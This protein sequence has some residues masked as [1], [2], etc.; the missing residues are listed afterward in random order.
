MKNLIFA[1]LFVLSFTKA[2]SQ[3]NVQG[4]NLI[5]QSY[6]TKVSVLVKVYDPVKKEVK[7]LAFMLNDDIKFYI[8]EVADSGYIISVWDFKPDT[9]K[10]N[11]YKSLDGEKG[12][13][14]LNASSNEYY[15]MSKAQLGIENTGNTDI[16]NKFKNLAY[17]DLWANNTQFFISLKDFNNK[18][19]PIYPH[20]RGFTWGFLTLPIKARFGNK[21]APFTFEEKINF[22]ISAGVKWQHVNTVYSASN[23][24]G[25]ISVG[26]VKL[27]KDNSAAAISLSAGYMYQYDKFQI[28]IFTG[29]DFIDKSRGIDWGYQGKPWLGF[30]IGFSLFGESKTSASNDQTQ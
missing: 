28:G 24:L 21:K 25:G 23:L 13:N 4:T 2:Y 7:D 9:A 10:T 19:E 16:L 14:N 5:G 26:G 3:T 15:K 20:K 18:C 6:V 27:D 30:A 12:G 29:L 17:V 1:L 11:F 22:G 8:Y